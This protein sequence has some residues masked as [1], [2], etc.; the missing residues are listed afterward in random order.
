MADTEYKIN[1]ILEAQ[2]E[3]L[4]LNENLKMGPVY[5]I[6]KNLIQYCL[7][8]IKYIY[9]ISKLKLTQMSILK[10][11]KKKSKA[12][13]AEPSKVKCIHDWEP[14]SEWIKLS[15]HEGSQK[16]GWIYFYECR[17]CHR[18]C[19]KPEEIS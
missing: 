12:E 9:Y 17:K 1:L 7:I 16:Y 14:K 8:G 3:M 11:F 10:F 2:N 18:K 19:N 15:D 6:K 4:F 5:K 13:T